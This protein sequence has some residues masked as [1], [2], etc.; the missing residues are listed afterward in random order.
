MA[1]VFWSY[2]DSFFQFRSGMLDA[3]SWASAFATLKRLLSNPAYR[4][5]GRPSGVL[6]GTII[7]PSWTG[8]SSKPGTTLHLR[9]WRTSSNNTLPKREALQ[10]S[11]A[12]NP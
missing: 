4:A 8:L 5:C 2:E 7:D 3:S 6:L 11:Q 9:S 1:S 10:K 12:F